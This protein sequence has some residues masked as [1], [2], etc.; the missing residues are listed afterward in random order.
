VTHIGNIIAMMSPW[1]DPSYLKRIWCIFEMYTSYADANCQIEIV[2]PPR[3]QES[4]IRA[5]VVGRD[6]KGNWGIDS[7]LSVLAQTKVE[8]AQASVESDKKYIFRLIE[9]GPGYGKLNQ[10]VNYLMRKWVRETMMSSVEEAESSL[11]ESINDSSSSQTNLQ[12][13]RGE[14]CDLI[15]YVANYLN[16]SGENAEAM[17]LYNRELEIIEGSN[18]IED[19]EF[20]MRKATCYGTIGTGHFYLGENEKAL[21]G[22]QQSKIMNEEIFG[23][24]H[25]RTVSAMFNI[26]NVQLQLGDLDNALENFTKCMNAYKNMYGENHAY[27]ADTYD[28]VGRCYEDKKDLDKALEMYIKAL[29]VRELCRGP[30][31]PDVAT[32][33]NSLA[34]LYLEKGECE[35]SLTTF[36]RSINIWEAVYGPEHPETA[37]SYLNIGLAHQQN[38]D[39]DKALQYF[40][41]SK[42]IREKFFGLDH[43]N[44]IICLKLINSV[45]E[46]REQKA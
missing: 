39:L 37:T 4:L 24:T 20:K 45:K 23:P 19:D 38:K 10:E 3:E 5:M 6:E 12:K 16:K 35:N 8:N 18:N 9:E 11:I 1:S 43:P 27:T 17:K 40:T 14:L 44:T 26:G 42:D 34:L 46:V 13:Q 25:Q 29:K 32:S 2:M 36:L 7:L 15:F 33:L 21:E 22:F 31:H 41:M 28:Y 30:N